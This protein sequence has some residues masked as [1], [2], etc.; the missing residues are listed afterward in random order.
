MS[1]RKVLVFGATGGVGSAVARTVHS[2]GLKVFLALRDTSK[3][4]PGLT[5]TDE[6]TAG[7]ER[8][9]ADLNKP[10]SV[11]DAVSKTGATHA[12]IYAVL[13]GSSDH[14]RSTAEALKAAGIEQVVLLSSYGTQGDIRTISPS[15]FIAY[16]HAQV[17]ISLDDVFGPEG[18]V[19]V[20]PAFFNTNVFWWKKQIDECGEVKI[21]FPD[22]KFDYISP[23]DV[24]AVCGTILAGVLEGEQETALS[25]VGPETDLSV[26]GA[27]EII[28][29]AIDKPMKVTKVSIDESVQLMVEKVGIPESQARFMT[30]SFENLGDGQDISPEVRANIERCLK[31]P[32]T[33]FFDWVEQNKDKLKA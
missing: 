24:G 29:R 16:E 32:A 25:L 20:R 21:S 33:R 17:E 12:F 30:E 15:N 6:Q 26:A 3:P 22:A 1:P 19:A 11:R 4:I 14:L 27:I 31:R 9:Q 7:Y 10:D 2:L 5:T 13:G 8:V 23:D 28:G 18:Y